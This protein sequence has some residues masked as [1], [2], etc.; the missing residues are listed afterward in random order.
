MRSRFGTLPATLAVAFTWS[1]GASQGLVDVTPPGAT[2]A[3]PTDLSADGAIV[4]GVDSTGFY[5]WSAMTGFV[6]NALQ[7]TSFNRL[8]ISGDGA[9]L[10]AASPAQR[11]S[12][13]SSE[14]L[15]C[16]VCSPVISMTAWASD[17]TGSTLV[18]DE[19]LKAVLWRT[20][21]GQASV[22]SVLDITAAFTSAFDISA[23]G[24]VVSGTWSNGTTSGPRIWTFQ[25]NPPGWTYFDPPA[26]ING[27][28]RISSDGTTLAGRAPL[29][30]NGNG[31]LGRWNA[32]D[33]FETFGTLPTAA[34]SVTM[35]ISGDGSKIVGIAAM[36]AGIPSRAVLWS[37]DTGIVDLNT[38]L[39]SLGLDLAGWSLRS[40]DAISDDGLVL[41]GTGRAPLDATPRAWLV[42]LPQRPALAIGYGA[43]CNGP[44]GPCDLTCTA[45]PWL[46][47]TVATRATGAPALGISVAAIGTAQIALPLSNLL[48]I[49]D[50]SCVVLTTPDLVQFLL[51]NGP[52]SEW[53]A[54]IPTAPSLLGAT[55]HHQI[56]HLFGDASG[57]LVA[58]SSTNGLSLTLGSL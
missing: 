15:P 47:R 14:L 28:V 7:T 12:A 10:L 25:Q 24:T 20:A 5:T 46:G 58:T 4:A 13:G 55:V 1:V 9:T 32:T 6:P 56:A 44:S 2:Y 42:R 40:C 36:G 11:L 50:P 22:P 31:Q 57:A 19:G 41:A 23:D 53:S 17:S 3:T 26:A 51:P 49:A 27:W 18:G 35:A 54:A 52:V 34:G 33:G 30:S 45:Q 16:A 48:S 8:A 29:G 43:G 21:P 37:R 39:P 38:W